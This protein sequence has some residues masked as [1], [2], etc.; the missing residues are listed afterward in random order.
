[1]PAIF[2]QH[3]MLSRAPA[4]DEAHVQLS[5]EDRVLIKRWWKDC[6]GEI[7]NHGYRLDD[8][9][10]PSSNPSRIRASRTFNSIVNTGLVI[11][12]TISLLLVLS[13]NRYGS[14]PVL[15]GKKTAFGLCSHGY[16]LSFRLPSSPKGILV[17]LV[18]RCSARLKCR[19]V[20]LISS[21]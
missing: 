8:Q 13:A 11:V 20:D 19:I 5:R 14:L 3:T 9:Y 16:H 4:S 10:I 12:G 18:Y 1:M 7:D 6:Y 2:S 15:S 21:W 17:I